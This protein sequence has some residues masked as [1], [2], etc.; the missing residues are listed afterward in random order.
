MADELDLSYNDY[1]RDEFGP[2]FV[3]AEEWAKEA[4]LARSVNR[5]LVEEWI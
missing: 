2:P 4:S 5:A 3:S 1:S